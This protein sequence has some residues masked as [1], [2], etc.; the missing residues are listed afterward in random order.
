MPLIARI[1]NIDGKDYPTIIACT[2]EEFKIYSKDDFLMPAEIISGQLLKK[3]LEQHGYMLDFTDKH[4]LES[5]RGFTEIPGKIRF[6]LTDAR[7]L[8]PDNARSYV[9]NICSWEQF[10][11]WYANELKKL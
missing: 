11:D 9:K 4:F 2:E 10:V 7:F 1:L 3:F 8:T 5:S 6:E